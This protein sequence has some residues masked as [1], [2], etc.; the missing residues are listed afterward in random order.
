MTY[1]SALFLGRMQVW[2]KPT[3]QDQSHGSEVAP[4]AHILEIEALV[5]S[6]LGYKRGC[7]VMTI[8]LPN[9][10]HAPAK[11]RFEDAV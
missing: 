7:K 3:E 10:Q 5:H 8:T 6:P 9:E 1:S 11:E 4:N 2:N